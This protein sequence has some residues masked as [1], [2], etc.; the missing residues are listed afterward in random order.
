MYRNVCLVRSNTMCVFFPLTGA[1]DASL[2]STSEGLSL[3]EVIK[4]F[5]QSYLRLACNASTDSNVLGF[6][7]E[8]YQ[9]ACRL[10]KA[11]LSFPETGVHIQETQVSPCVRSSMLEIS[12]Y[13]ERGYGGSTIV[14]RSTSADNSSMSYSANFT[15]Q[16]CI[17]NNVRFS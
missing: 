6:R 9:P 3:T 13:R 14:C 7:W 11:L 4:G 1:V 8:V 12:D 2:K 15:V 17:N 16:G 5:D 10:Q